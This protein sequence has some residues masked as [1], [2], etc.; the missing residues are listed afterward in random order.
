MLL[1]PH[2]LLDIDSRNGSRCPLC[3][4]ATLLG[5]PCYQFGSFLL[6]ELSQFTL[7][8]FNKVL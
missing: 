4:L 7:H 6:L 5:T 8:K 1:M 2:C 3:S